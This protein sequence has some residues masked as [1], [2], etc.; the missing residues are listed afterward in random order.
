MKCPYCGK[1][2]NEKICPKCYAAIPEKKV[3]IK[4]ESAKK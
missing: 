2:T 1:E 4:K 3:A